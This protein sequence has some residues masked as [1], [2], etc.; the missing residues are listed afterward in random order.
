MRG[1]RQKKILNISYLKAS[2]WCMLREKSSRITWQYECII[3]YLSIHGHIMLYKKWDW[4]LL[5]WNAQQ[6][7]FNSAICC[8]MKKRKPLK[9]VFWQDEYGWEG[10][11]VRGVS[12]FL[13]RITALSPQCWF[14]NSSPL[15]IHKERS[16][17]ALKTNR[18]VIHTEIRA[19]RL[20]KRGD[21]IGHALTSVCFQGVSQVSPLSI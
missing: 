2:I 9:S 10:V 17:S 14:A 7:N 21:G 6:H 15:V 12:L 3:K 19:L 8:R 18:C 5:S 1:I 16:V 20:L 4:Q 11:G 13:L